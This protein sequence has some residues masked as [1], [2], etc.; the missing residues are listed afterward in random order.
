VPD[1]AT[2]VSPQQRTWLLVLAVLA[3]AG[4]VESVRRTGVESVVCGVGALLALAVLCVVWRARVVVDFDGVQDRVLLRRR[5]VAWDEV[6]TFHVTR[7]RGPWPGITVVAFCRSG[8][9]VPLF[10]LTIDLVPSPA[11]THARLRDLAVEL[12]TTLANRAAA[13]QA[14]D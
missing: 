2:M 8:Q 5:R 11:T 7:P 9:E 6:E 3:V 14:E 12:N 1:E 10:G 4:L 13:A